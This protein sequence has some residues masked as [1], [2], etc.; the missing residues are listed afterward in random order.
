MRR[1]RTLAL[2]ESRVVSELFDKRHKTLLCA[3]SQAVFVPQ[4]ALD[5]TMPMPDWKKDLLE[6]RKQGRSWYGAKGV[7]FPCL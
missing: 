4:P 2:L 3:H 1:A 7:Y 6:K 5:A